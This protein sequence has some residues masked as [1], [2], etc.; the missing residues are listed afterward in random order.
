MIGVDFNDKALKRTPELSYYSYQ[1]IIKENNNQ[2]VLLM[3][4]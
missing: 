4:K 3:R 2:C 1:K